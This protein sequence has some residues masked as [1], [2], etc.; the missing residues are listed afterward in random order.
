[1]TIPMDDIQA[2]VK[3]NPGQMTEPEYARV[4]EEI[5]AVAPGVIVVFGAGRDTFLWA[6]ANR[7]G[8]TWVVDDSTKWLEAAWRSM[9]VEGDQLPPGGE[10]FNAVEVKYKTKLAEWEKWLDADLS[11]PDLCP[12]AVHPQTCDLVLVDGP[13]G[14]GPKVPGRMQPI[15]MAS[16]LTKPGGAVLVHDM[17]RSVERQFTARFL[18]KPAGMVHHL[19]IWAR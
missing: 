7:G 19:G 11:M 13:Q 12:Y 9:G 5:E 10:R 14:E 17:H 2:L 4:Y 3:R 18:G 16:V 15:Y 8:M 6:R 1:M